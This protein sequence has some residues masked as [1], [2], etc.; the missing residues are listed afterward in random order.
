MG[1]HQKVTV[2]EVLERLEENGAIT[3]GSLA[4]QFEV[5]EPTMRSRIREARKDGESIIHSTNGV[6]LIRK[7]DL[8]DPLIAEAMRSFTN[9]ILSCV[10]GQM[11]MANPV[12]PLLPAMRRALKD[13]MSAGERRQL[14]KSCT[15]VRAL[16]DLVEV[17]EEMQ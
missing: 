10:K 7:E 16:I 3:I 13:N 4:Q 15:T 6:Q 9:W 8:T 1:R 5:S 2:Q 14:A 12:Q 11:I 17:D